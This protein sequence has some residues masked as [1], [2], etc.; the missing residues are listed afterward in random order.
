MRGFNLKSTETAY[1]LLINSNRDFK[2]S[3]PFERLASFY[4]TIS[5]NFQRFQCFKCTFEKNFQKS[6]N[7]NISIQN[8]PV[9]SQYY[10]KKNRMGSTKWS[11]HKGRSFA[12]N[13]FIFLKILFQLKNLLQGFKQV[14]KTWRGALQNL[15]GGLSQYMGREWGA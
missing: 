13:C 8:C 5:G 4:V 6:E 12:S 7:R 15:M 11:Y 1:T 2:N 10:T 3:P 14:L 9:R